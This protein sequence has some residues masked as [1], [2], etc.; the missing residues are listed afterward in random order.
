MQYSEAHRILSSE[1]LIKLCVIT[2]KRPSE[3]G[4]E[5][6]DLKN[7]CELWSTGHCE[8]GT[9]TNVTRFDANFGSYTISVDYDGK[10]NKRKHGDTRY[11]RRSGF[12]NDN[13]EELRRYQS[14]IGH[15]CKFYI[16]YVENQDDN[17]VFCTLLDVK[18]LGVS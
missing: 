18:D 17:S 6:V 4:K 8:Y 1:E 14:L 11:T 15:K 7:E 10:Q 16:G 13:G 3:I 5:I 2:G 12:V 9:I